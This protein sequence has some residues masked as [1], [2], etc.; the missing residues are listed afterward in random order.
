MLDY[1]NKGQF[2][3]YS[4]TDTSNWICCT[5]SSIQ[6]LRCVIYETSEHC[7]ILQMRM[8]FLSA[9]QKQSDSGIKF[10]VRKYE[11]HAVCQ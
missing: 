5:E 3:F 7:S 11:E 8:N 6:R 4:Y 2:F 10:Q 1:C 9:I